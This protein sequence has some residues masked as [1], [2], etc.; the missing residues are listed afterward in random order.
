MAINLQK[1][2]KIDLTKKSGSKLTNFCVG[3][4]WGAIETTKKTWFSG[5]KKVVEAVDL[6]ASCVLLDAN[7]Q[8]LD[9]VFF[10]QLR[11]RDGSI[12]HSG[13][14]RTGDVG[15]DDGLDNEV[16]S[17]RLDVIAPEVDQV[18]FFFLGL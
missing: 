11:S 15:G 6:D 14:D 10:N 16:I 5:E 17:V 3:V 13:D 4:N 7:K 1:G 2:Q 8:P 12:V 9:V 18:V